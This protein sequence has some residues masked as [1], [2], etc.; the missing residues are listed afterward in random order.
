MELLREAVRGIIEMNVGNRKNAIWY[1]LAREGVRPSKV[2]KVNGITRQAIN[3]RFKRDLDGL[4]LASYKQIA[5][6]VEKPVGVVIDE[7]L[8]IEKRFNEAYE[9]AE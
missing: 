3:L 2:A 1:Y 8:G 4:S 9:E 7:I 5:K 6:A